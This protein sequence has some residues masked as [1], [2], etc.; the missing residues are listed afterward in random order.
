MSKGGCL[1]GLRCVSQERAEHR[2]VVVPVVPLPDP[3][4]QVAGKPPSRDRVMGPAQVGLEVA[5][6]P[7]DCVR[8]DV[9]AHVQALAVVNAAMLEALTV[10]LAVLQAQPV[11]DPTGDI[12]PAGTVSVTVTVPL[13]SP[14]G[15][16]VTSASNPF[17]IVMVPEVKLS[18]SALAFTSEASRKT[19]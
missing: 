13:L 16:G 18:G 1:D 9:A 5:E 7:F 6:E 17:V 2:L 12:K 3:F 10:K 19:G 14:S 8:V 11:P 15:R 4:V